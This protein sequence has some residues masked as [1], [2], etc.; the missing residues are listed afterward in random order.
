[1]TDNLFEGAED[2]QNFDPNKDYVAEL[3]GE[4]KKF[5]TVADLAR[6]KAEADLFIQTVV[7]QKDD[8]SKDYL[9][10]REEL[11]AK[12]NLQDLVDR[13]NAKH[14]PSELPLNDGSREPKQLEPKDIE[15][16]IS[17]KILDNKRLEEES[18][19]LNVVQ[20]KLKERF[21]ASSASVLKEQANTLRLTDDDVHAL[22]KK[23]PEAFFRVMGLNQEKQETFQAPP[24]TN[25]RNDSFVPAGGKKRTWSYY[26]E[27]K[28]SNPTLYLDKKT[29]TQMH[30]DSAELGDAFEDGDFRAL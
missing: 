11:D 22:A 29:Q 3:V 7:K 14:T 5:K 4:G 13:L 1:M 30:K 6:G 21:G 19:N 17:K 23:S 25:Q 26:Q 15:D 2:N 10:M 12:A 8:L 24:R 20:A 28:K 27:L 16:L 18:Y 9:R